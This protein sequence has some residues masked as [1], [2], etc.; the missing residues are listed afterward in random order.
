LAELVSD[1]QHNV[2]PIAVKEDQRIAAK[3]ALL[4][5]KH[6]V[7]DVV[8]AQPHSQVVVEETLLQTG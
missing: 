2:S 8:G 6:R 4:P 5:I 1:I 3:D 7:E